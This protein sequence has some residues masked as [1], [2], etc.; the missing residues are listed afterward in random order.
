MIEEE[1]S[2]RL[3][4]KLNRYLIYLWLIV[5]IV[6]LRGEFKVYFEDFSRDDYR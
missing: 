6:T 5:G 4:L 2:L 3:P 1:T